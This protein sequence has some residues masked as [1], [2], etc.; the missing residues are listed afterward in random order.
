MILAGGEGRRFKQ[1]GG[2]GEKALFKVGGRAMIRRVIDAVSEAVDEWVV[3]VDSEARAEK[4][5]SEVGGSIVVDRG[6]RG[7]LTGVATG[8]EELS[9][10]ACLV[11]P[12]DQPF[13]SSSVLDKLLSVVEEGWGAAVPLWPSGLP[14]PLMA[15]Y[16]RRPAVALCGALMA[17]DRAR[18]D[19]LVRAG[20]SVSFLSV[21]SELR[22][23]DP[24]LLSFINVNRPMDVEARPACKLVV[25]FSVKVW[26]RLDPLE[27]A[28]VAVEALGS[29]GATTL[30]RLNIPFWHGLHWKVK[31]EGGEGGSY[32]WREA[33]KWFRREARLYASRRLRLLEARALMDASRC[34]SHVDPERSAK[35]RGR[36]VSIY[37][38]LGVEDKGCAQ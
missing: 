34:L 8:L 18:P 20:L 2:L 19:D 7:P 35:L 12:C 5:R 14:E 22:P 11:V 9:A 6:P 29:S 17:Y 13:L 32:A 21:T 37:R 16:S 38:Q 33:A 30:S 28:R 24:E 15:A 25:G 36:A 10:T 23:L 4:L 26:Q 3:A 1:A 31:A 27:V